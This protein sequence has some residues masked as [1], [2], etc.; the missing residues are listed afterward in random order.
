MLKVLNIE[1]FFNTN[2]YSERATL[3]TLFLCSNSALRLVINSI[4][5]QGAFGASQIRTVQ[6]KE[7]L[8]KKPLFD[9]D[10]QDIE[11]SWAL[12]SSVI[13]QHSIS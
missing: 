2:T 7:P 8:I 6:S 11:S 10:K 13:R 4:W 12:K 1:F 5:V 9:Q 3:V